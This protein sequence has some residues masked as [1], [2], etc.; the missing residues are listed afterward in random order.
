MQAVPGNKTPKSKS[1]SSEPI[2]CHRCNAHVPPG[3]RFCNMCGS[4]LNRRMPR[5]IPSA[6]HTREDAPKRTAEVPVRPTPVPHQ[7]KPGTEPPAGTSSLNLGAIPEAGFTLKRSIEIIQ[8]HQHIPAFSHQ[9]IQVM[10]VMGNDETSFRHLTNTIL[11]DYSLTLAILR[12][13]NSAYYNRSGKSVC[14]VARA[15]TM[16][17][18]D[19]VKRIA[20]G[21]M[22][23]ENY[24]KHSAG[25]K[26]LLL[27]SMLTASQSREAAQRLKIPDAEGIYLCGMFRNLGEILVAIFFA[28]AYDKILKKINEDKILEHE[29]CTEVLNF[30]YEELGRAIADAWALPDSVCH[31]MDHPSHVKGQEGSAEDK[32]R[33]LVA[34][35]HELTHCIYRQPTEN[36]SQVIDDLIEKYGSI[37]GMNRKIVQEVLDEAVTD[38]KETFTMVGVPLNDLHLRHQYQLA[39]SGNPAPALPGQ[40]TMAAL[41]DAACSAAV[42]QVPAAPEE[43]LLKGLVSEVKAAMEPGHE[44]KL[45]E[46]IMMAIEACH[47]GAGLD[48]VVFCLASPDRTCVRGRLGLGLSIDEVIDR[49]QVPLS[50][51]EEALTI[52]LSGKR[53]IFID[54]QSDDRYQDSALLRTLNPACFG[55]YPVVVDDVGVGALY[56]DKQTHNAVPSNT[57]LDTV[58]MVRDLLAEMIRRTRA[59]AG[60]MQ[61]VDRKHAF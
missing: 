3:S 10:G 32:M 60:A 15:V 38:T 24:D 28:E 39:L 56:F 51:H 25:L 33:A 8:G 54:V 2:T 18:I 31:S 58:G 1:E 57:V 16:M 40:G 53:D 20:A 14:S 35:S 29:A 36:R 41:T 30:T 46:V 34:F 49:F 61:N 6:L 7:A 4:A 5:I 9:I 42:S 55:F 45:N 13:A 11:H 19:A 52:P 44:L 59:A 22:L 26:E 43:D 37:A 12:L 21:L 48:R 17:G 47:R 23:L 50:G 27:L